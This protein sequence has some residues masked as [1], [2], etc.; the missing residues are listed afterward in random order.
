MAAY[1]ARRIM[2]GALDYVAVVTKY[3]EFKAD[4]DVIL[5]ANN[6]QDLI[7]E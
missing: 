5:I 3:P 6:R 7:V 2:E 1:L 4:I